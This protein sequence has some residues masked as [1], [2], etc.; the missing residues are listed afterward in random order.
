MNSVLYIKCEKVYKL[1]RNNENLL[2]CDI[3]AVYQCNM[4]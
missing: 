3:D 4:K 1:I 2:I